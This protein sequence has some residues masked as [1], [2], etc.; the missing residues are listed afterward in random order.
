MLYLLIFFFQIYFVNS[1]QFFNEPFCCC[2]RPSSKYTILH[3]TISFA[4]L[5]FNSFF[6][7]LSFPITILVFPYKK[8]I[9]Q[10]KCLFHLQSLP[11]ANCLLFV[12]KLPHKLYLVRPPDLVKFG[13]SSN[14]VFCGVVVPASLI[15]R[16]S[17]NQIL[18]AHTHTH[19]IQVYVVSCE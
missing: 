8:F 2:I 16:Y 17:E 4:N 3:I 9:R 13:P 1:L 15:A 7:I 6:R 14:W 11:A 10:I 18:H 5:N 19:Y 12:P